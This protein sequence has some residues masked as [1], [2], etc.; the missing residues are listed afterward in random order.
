MDA[1]Q[2]YA[3]RAGFALSLV[4][5]AAVMTNGWEPSDGVVT[6]DDDR[7]SWLGLGASMRIHA[8]LVRSLSS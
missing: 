5:I 7:Q 4:S 2:I 8:P 1:A 6:D 3:L